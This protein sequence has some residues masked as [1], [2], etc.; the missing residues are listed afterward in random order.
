MG[1]EKSNFDLTHNA[2]SLLFVCPHKVTFTVSVQL[3]DI[4]DT[5][6]GTTTVSLVFCHARG[7]EEL[8]IVR[9]E[10]FWTSYQQSD[11]RV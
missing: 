7:I 10:R 3:G 4:S 5:P 6:T 2:D 9:D 11:T 1:G 8:P